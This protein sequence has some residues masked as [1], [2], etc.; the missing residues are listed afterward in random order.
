MVRVRRACR[1]M[2]PVTVVTRLATGLGAGA[3]PEVGRRADLLLVRASGIDDVIADGAVDP[4][5]VDHVARF[6]R[7]LA[8]PE[9]ER[10]N[11]QVFVVHGGM[12]A[13]MAPPSLEARF[14]AD[15]GQWDEAG[16]AAAVGGYFADRDDR[17]FVAAQLEG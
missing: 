10:V 11:G 12:V 14:D 13:L 2:E 5:S 8:G 6:V 7:F 3:D 4:L 1:R 17:M 9:A 15:G 16:L